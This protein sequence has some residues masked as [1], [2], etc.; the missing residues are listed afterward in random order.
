[1]VL[2][3]LR[4]KTVDEK[5]P[6]LPAGHDHRVTRVVPEVADQIVAL[7]VARV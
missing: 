1:V 3:P 7:L 6:M 2:G 4:W 5:Q